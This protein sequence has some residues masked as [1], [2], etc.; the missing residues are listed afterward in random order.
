MALKLMR[1][2]A[3]AAPLVLIFVPGWAQ[4]PAGGSAVAADSVV[5]RVNGKEIRRS[6]VEAAQKSLPPQ[7]RTMPLA[8]IFPALLTQMI[9]TALVAD[10]A[11]ADG[12]D[13]TDAVRR[14]LA[15][16]ETSILEDAYMQRLF[17]GKITEATL[18][19]RYDATTGNAPGEE[20]VRVRHILVK[21]EAE[22]VAIIKELDGGADFVALA[23]GKSTGPSGSS[24]G[25]LGFFAHGS[26]VPPFADAAFALDKGKFTSRPVKTRFGWHVIK[27]EDRRKS[28]APSFEESRELLDREMTEE[29]AGAAVAALRSKARIEQFNMDGTPKAPPRFQRVPR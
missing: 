2:A 8:A 7:Y 21:T 13:K 19:A 6:D 26:M 22:A 20:Q 29:I 1:V 3:I 25:D 24:G 10:A 5:A 16:L 4:S 15:T 12:L 11:R 18:R 27:L 23:R 28:A 17:T 9:N 14:R